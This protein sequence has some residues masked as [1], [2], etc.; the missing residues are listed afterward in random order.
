MNIRFPLHNLNDEEFEG[1]VTLICEK[2]L[3]LGTIVFSKG[4]D[5]GRDAKFTG[6]SNKYPSENSPWEGKFIVQ[7][8]H[9]TKPEASCSESDF[10]TLLKKE[11]PKIKK[12]KD[13]G[14]LDYYLLFTNRKL[15]GI[16]DSKIEDVLSEKIDV[17]NRIIG[18]ERIQ[19]WLQEYTDIVKTL[20]LNKLL[21]PIE[22][23]EEDIQEIITTF[24]ETKIPKKYLKEIQNEFKKI[25]IEVKN[26]LNRLGK[27]YFDNVLKSSYSDFDKIKA[28]LQDPRNDDFKKKY[29]NTI[30]DLQEEIFIHREEYGAF[31]NILNHLYKLILDVSNDKLKNNR[32]LI[33]VFLHYMYVNCDIGIKEL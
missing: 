16:Q 24:A 12:I 28:F 10:K 29:N 30:S 14:K 1:L 9:T 18:I 22:F 2:I 27:D 7:A 11:L 21:L 31:E 5:G 3:G 26:K 17:V 15:S 8:K 32:K 23:Y 13:S 25:P 20:E 4:K 6:K 33:R 19:L